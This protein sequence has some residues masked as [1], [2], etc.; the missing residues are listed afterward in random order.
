MMGDIEFKYAT[1]EITVQVRL[2]VTRGWC[3]GAISG[4]HNTVRVWPVV[5]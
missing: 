5:E 4:V 2:T 1:I 3:D